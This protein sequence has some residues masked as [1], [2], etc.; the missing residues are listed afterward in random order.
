MLQV[1][2]SWTLVQTAVALWEGI[3]CSV[4]PRKYVLH[5]CIYHECDEI[6]FWMWC[7]WLCVFEDGELPGVV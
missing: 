4:K 2:G 6:E 1:F 7:G 5:M 3:Y